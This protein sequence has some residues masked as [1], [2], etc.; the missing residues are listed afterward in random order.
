M[1]MFV[2]VKARMLSLTRDHSCKI[3]VDMNAQNEST[4]VLMYGRVYGKCINIHIY[5]HVI[6][7][8]ERC[9][10]PCVAMSMLLCIAS[11]LAYIYTPMLYSFVRYVVYLAWPCVCHDIYSSAWWNSKR[12]SEW[13]APPSQ[14]TL[15]PEGIFLV[16]SHVSHILANNYELRKIPRLILSENQAA[17][18]SSLPCGSTVT[19]DSFCLMAKILIHFNE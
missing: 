7:I 3:F 2:C 1:C 15:L 4:C 14:K 19:Q 11:A 6:Y 10:V 8:C 13:V 5:T 16:S 17:R 9:C 12:V 18:A